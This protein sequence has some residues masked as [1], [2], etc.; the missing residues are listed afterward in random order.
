MAWPVKLALAKDPKRP[1]KT[2]MMFSTMSNL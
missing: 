1:G 2:L